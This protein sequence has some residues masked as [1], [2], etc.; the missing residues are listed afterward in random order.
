MITEDEPVSNEEMPAPSLVVEV[1]LSSDT[2]KTS[3]Q[4]DY[5]RK[6]TEYAQRGVS[7]YWI[8]DPHCRNRLGVDFGWGGLSGG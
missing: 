3:R 1:A 4:R 5:V 8:V 6:R 2:D 7:E